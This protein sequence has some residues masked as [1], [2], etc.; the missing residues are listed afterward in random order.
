M[1]ILYVVA[2]PIGNLSD[3]TYRAVETLKEVDFVAC[4]DTRHSKVLLSHYAI[5]KPLVS[6]HQHSKIGKIDYIIDRIKNGESGALVSDAGTPGISDPGGVLVSAAVAAGIK[7]VPIPGV[8]A[9]T[10][11]ISVLGFNAQEFT[12]IGFLP[13]KK[14]RQT[15]LNSF[16]NRKHPVI[17]YES[18]LRFEKTI[19]EMAN[20]FALDT[21]VVIGRELT[22]MYEEIIRGNLEE[23][24]A[25]LPSINMKGEFVI[26]LI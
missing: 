23:I 7:V 26:C 4:E 15:L 16:K 2:T 12:F 25:K 8:S 5:D 21:Q 18:P 9:L 22:K 3:I 19:L 1:G 11:L 20:Y 24:I 10:A 14:G 13:K 6:Y 17:F